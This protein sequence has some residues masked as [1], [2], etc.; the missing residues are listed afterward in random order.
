MPD[1]AVVEEKIGRIEAE[2]KR[3][4]IWQEKPIEPE[5]LECKQAFCMDTMSFSQWLQFILLPRV[6]GIIAEKG[7]FPSGS[8]V[9]VQA[10]RE[11]DGFYEASDLIGLLYEFD[12][13]F[14]G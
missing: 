7:Q 5:R 13:L 9:A 6:K 2:M 1:Y 14:G 3:I 11:F 4:G 8:M 10:T 12:R